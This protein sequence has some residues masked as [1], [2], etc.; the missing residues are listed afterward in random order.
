MQDK[1]L[2]IAKKFTDEGWRGMK[3][4]LD[5]EMPVEEKNNKRGLIFWLSGISG[6]AAILGGIY[7]FNFTEL[8]THNSINKNKITTEI[9]KSKNNEFYTKHNEQELAIIKTEKFEEKNTI[10]YSKVT[11]TVKSNT[12]N[13]NPNYNKNNN[14]SIE[15]QVFTENN[16][17]LN[18]EIPELINNYNPDQKTKKSELQIQN[19][20][21]AETLKPQVIFEKN[22]AIASA[23]ETD[24]IERKTINKLSTLSLQAFQ[25]KTKINPVHLK[26]KNPIKNRKNTAFISSLFRFNSKASG[27]S[28][29]YL[30]EIKAINNNWSIHAGLSYKYISQPIEYTLV[31]SL[32]SEADSSGI[33][34]PAESS[35]QLVNIS[36]ANTNSL[37]YLDRNGQTFVSNSPNITFNKLKLHYLTMPFSVKYQKNRIWFG[38]GVEAGILLVGKNDNFSGGVAKNFGLIANDNDDERF[39]GNDPTGERTNIPDLSNFDFS[40]TLGTGFSLSEN[41]SIQASYFH[42]LK[43]VIKNNSTKDYNHLIQLSIQYSW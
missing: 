27:V 39:I 35:G 2:H 13:K 20:E 42:G 33:S 12:Q 21:S 28:L 26:E 18:N 43:D 8:N 32:G 11:E 41:A 15:N 29:G 1:N 36:Y 19:P 24:I 23:S 22:N 31:S 10:T 6:I 16:T 9:N 37:E 34:T 4:L 7:F 14:N 5:K 30:R 3:L 40:A 25:N 17:I 38:G